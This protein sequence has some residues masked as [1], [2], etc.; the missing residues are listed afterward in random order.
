[1][2]VGLGQEASAYEVQPS[3]G[4]TPEQGEKIA[5]QNAWVTGL[6]ALAVFYLIYRFLIK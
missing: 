3:A 4:I 6:G 5:V 2:F 1:M